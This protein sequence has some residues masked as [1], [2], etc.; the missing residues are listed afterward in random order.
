MKHINDVQVV[1]IIIISSITLI[2]ICNVLICLCFTQKRSCHPAGHLSLRLTAH[3][4]QVHQ[5]DLRY[6]CELISSVMM[7]FSVDLLLQAV[8][9]ASVSCERPADAVNDCVSQFI[10]ECPLMLLSAGVKHHCT[11]DLRYNIP[12]ENDCNVLCSTGGRI[13]LRS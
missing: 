6:D 11:K 4:L 13:S 9:S 1:I 12:Q 3:F 2:F 5:I 8:L 7:W 10:V